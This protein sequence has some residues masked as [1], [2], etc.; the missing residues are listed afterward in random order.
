M[1]KKQ[2]L[3][4]FLIYQEIAMWEESYREKHC[5]G[6]TDDELSKEGWWRGE[7]GELYSMKLGEARERRFAKRLGELVEKRITAFVAQHN[8]LRE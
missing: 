1:E 6:K 3:E 4:S 7:D 5:K 2:D 8:S